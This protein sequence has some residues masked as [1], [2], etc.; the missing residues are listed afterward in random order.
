M[1]EICFTY[2]KTF[3][4]CI[5]III[6]RHLMPLSCIFSL[7][8]EYH[9][10]TEHRAE[11]QRAAGSLSLSFRQENENWFLYS[12]IVLLLQRCRT[13][14]LTIGAYKAHIHLEFI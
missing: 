10:D 14:F 13:H 8:T 2:A 3:E 6:I 1:V 12:I 7:A 9:V 5:P 4:N 11:K